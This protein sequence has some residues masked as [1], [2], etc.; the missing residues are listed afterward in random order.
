MRS[1][2]LNNKKNAKLRKQSK[3]GAGAIGVGSMLPLRHLERPVRALGKAAGNA[4]TWATREPTEEELAQ[5]A[6]YHTEA[7]ENKGF[8]RRQKDKFMGR[9]P[10]KG[11][12]KGVEAVSA[13]LN[14]GLGENQLQTPRARVHNWQAEAVGEMQNAEHP[15]NLQNALSK[16]HNLQ[17]QLTD[18][19]YNR[20]QVLR[21]NLEQHIANLSAQRNELQSQIN[22]NQ[23]NLDVQVRERNQINSKII[24]QLADIN[25]L[26]SEIHLMEV[27]L[28]ALAKARPEIE[29]RAEVP[30][31]YRGIGKVVR[32]RQE[33]QRELNTANDKRN[34]LKGKLEPARKHRNQSKQ[35][36]NALQM[37]RGQINKQE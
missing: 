5:S 37:R 6:R 12:K 23:A 25:R 8:L 21:E 17:V 26:D 32:A 20:E 28:N 2:K 7:E 9:T 34:N 36:H 29:K 14:R 3:G 33:A 10:S 4:Y 22:A 31:G 11:R 18:A 35:Q 16:A 30:T 24:N 13:A 19:D 15:K 1:K 27:E